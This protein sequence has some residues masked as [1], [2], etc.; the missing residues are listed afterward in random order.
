MIEVTLWTP[1]GIIGTI[2]ILED[3]VDKGRVLTVGPPD[4]TLPLH[5]TVR[6][7]SHVV[8]IS[9]AKDPFMGAPHI[10][11]LRHKIE[12]CLR[13]VVNGEASWSPCL[14][15]LNESSRTWQCVDNFLFARNDALCGRCGY[16]SLRL[17]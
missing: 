6:L 15:F 10:E 2:V 13:L 8:N 17:W 16:S 3:T 11:Y 12:I 9:I 4:Q 5:S 7:L 1:E 14:A